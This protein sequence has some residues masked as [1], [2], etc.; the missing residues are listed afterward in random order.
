[1][2]VELKD[3]GIVNGLQ[4]YEV[5]E[6]NTGKVIGLNQSLPIDEETT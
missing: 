2:D 5:I 3:I 4:T 6:T 1:M